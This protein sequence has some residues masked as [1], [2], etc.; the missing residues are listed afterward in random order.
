MK[1]RP[2]R[3][4]SHRSH[5]LAAPALVLFGLYVAPAWQQASFAQQAGGGQP[6]PAAPAGRGGGG[7]IPPEPL[8]YTDR[9]GWTSIFDGATLKGW[10]ANPAVWTIENGAITAVSTP[11]RRVGTT[12]VIYQE[13]LAN[14]ELK[15]EYKVDGEIHSGIA[16]RSWID[17]ARAAT[18]GPAAAPPAGSAAARGGARAAGGAAPGAAR[19]G[20]AGGGRGTP[21]Q[22]P[23]DPKWM[24]YGP[25]MDFDAGHVM[26]GNVEERGTPRREIAWRG[27]MVRTETGKW[28]R[29][30]GS[31]GDAAALM[32]VIKADDWNQMHIIARGNALVHVINGTVMTILFDDDPTF[33]TPKG[34]VGMSIEGGATGRVSLRNVWLKKLQ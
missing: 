15:F 8:D 7:F 17:P 9:A 23:S 11:E 4:S 18:L 1:Q 22:V 28:P 5:W 2:D 20:G 31:L 3:S 30:I 14:F 10:D 19:A 32:N 29:V 16:Y 25:G 33:F 12:Y 26:S 34:L 24:L 21:P 6:P 13:E 27:G